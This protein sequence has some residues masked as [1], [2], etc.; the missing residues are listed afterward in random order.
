MRF[1]EKIKAERVPEGA[2]VSF[3]GVSFPY[4]KKTYHMYG[5]A[6]VTF[7]YTGKEL[8]RNSTSDWDLDAL[9]VEE[10]CF[11]SDEQY[12]RILKRARSLA[13][14]WLEANTEEAEA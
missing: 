1:T 11:D 8:I 7:T 9:G 5:F 10:D 13:C 2:K 12:G 14:A 3:D 4:G 6:V